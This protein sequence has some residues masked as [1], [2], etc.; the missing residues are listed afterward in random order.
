MTL[1]SALH[2]LMNPLK[3]VQEGQSVRIPGPRGIV[4][5]P[6]FVKFSRPGRADSG[7][8]VVAVLHVRRP[9]AGNDFP[10]LSVHE[11]VGR[12]PRRK[13][14][15]SCP[16]HVRPVRSTPVSHGDVDGLALRVDLEAPS[17]LANH[18]TVPGC[19][20]LLHHLGSDRLRVHSPDQILINSRRSIVRTALSGMFRSPSVFVSSSGFPW[21]TTTNSSALLT[22]SFS[23]AITSRL[24]AW[25]G[26]F[27][28]KSSSRSPPVVL[29]VT[30]TFVATLIVHFSY[31][32]KVVRRRGQPRG[33]R[34]LH[35][36]RSRPNAKRRAG[37]RSPP[38]NIRMCD[39]KKRFALLHN[40]KQVAS[41]LPMR[42]RVSADSLYLLLGRR[43]AEAR[44]KR[45]G[46]AWSQGQLAKACHLTRGSIANIEIGRQRAPL[47]TIWQI[48]AALGI[49]PRLLL[50]TLDELRD[51]TTAL[52]SPRLEAWITGAESELGGVMMKTLTLSGDDHET[53]DASRDA[54]ASAQDKKGSSRRVARR[55]T[56]RST[57]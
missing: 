54:S 37:L 51:S 50:P 53:R 3:R 11:D 33:P 25:R 42:V 28:G 47:H 4:Q 48:G 29:N 55:A 46:G 1:G 26:W 8:R 23:R 43:I 38:P 16:Q 57:R 36:L 31:A 34:R 49:E 12:R 2:Q 41:I 6:L 52:G 30:R 18:S 13:V 39:K 44:S 5:V 10:G 22:S 35:H 40:S 32:V 14:V 15:E 19:V 7:Q 45:S 17:V 27:A 24:R 21:N 20:N 9:G 56:V